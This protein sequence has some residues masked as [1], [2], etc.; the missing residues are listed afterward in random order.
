MLGCIDL[1]PYLTNNTIFVDQERLAEHAQI[2]STIVS[3][4]AIGI[5]E[6]RD[7]C[8][9]ICQEW[10]GQA[11]FVRKLL[12]RADTILAHTQHD[13]ATLLHHVIRV[14]E[15]ACLFCTPGGV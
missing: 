9:S 8:I 13:N 12:M 1:I 4:L 6:L 10:E 3:L 15:T 14:T 5:I 11:I 7:S 2:G